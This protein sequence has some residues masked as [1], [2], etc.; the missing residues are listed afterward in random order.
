META[1]KNT[2]KSGQPSA[3]LK[4][5]EIVVGLVGPVGTDLGRTCSILEAELAHFRYNQVVIRLSSLLSQ[6]ADY[7]DKLQPEKNSTEFDRI[8]NYMDAGTSLRRKTK[9]G[10]ILGLMAV[11]AI[12][13]NRITINSTNKRRKNSNPPEEEL[14]KRPIPRTAYVLNSLKHPD[15]VKLL[16]K[17]YGKGFILLSVY[18]P[19]EIR[20][21]ALADLIATK[22]RKGTSRNYKDRAY[23]LIQRDEEEE[24]KDHLGQNVGL[25]FPLADLFVDSR[26]L[27]KQRSEIKRFLEKFFGHS[28]HS[29]TKDEFG[30]FQAKA[31]SIRS[32]DMSR[33]VGAVITSKDGEVL[34]VGCNEIPKFGG[35]LYWEGDNPDKRDFR[36]GYDSS[37]K[38]RERMI[39]EV[40][41]AFYRNG[42]LKGGK[43]S[44]GMKL[45]KEIAEE[46]SKDLFDDALV[47][48]VIEYGRS[49]HAEMAALMSAARNGIS[50]KDGIL[51]S[52][53]FPCHLCARHIIAAGISRVV[54]I[55]PYP[56]SIAPSL[57][58]DSIV[59]DS[60]DKVS[61]KVA[62][63]PFVGVSPVIYLDL[64]SSEGKRKTASGDNVPWNPEDTLPRIDRFEN[65]YILVETKALVESLQPL[66]RKN[67]IKLLAH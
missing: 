56:K 12:R 42:F 25:A 2:S 41:D 7:R 55:E 63:E 24:E 28:Y 65:S 62:F 60:P 14:G 22:G 43:S 53:T 49:V 52:T 5:P 31:A 26:D 64:F 10:D 36:L 37:V 17:I 40:V 59:V 19:K 23:Q 33:Q 29:P 4:D 57:Y 6:I 20:A 8:K 61:G 34:A 15:E 39:S 51:Y 13:E 21:E 66:L 18:S 50:V 9:R 47:S 16:R 38:Y 67:N 32:A 27:E 54:Y 1:E 58:D 30:M 44:S 35:G 3:V 45:A 48:N 11:A 46:K